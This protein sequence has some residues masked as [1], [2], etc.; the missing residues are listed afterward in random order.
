MRTMVNAAAPNVIPT[1]ATVL[2][3]CVSAAAAFCANPTIPC[4]ALE[5]VNMLEGEGLWLRLIE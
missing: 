3:F 5:I 1:I 4:V 2:N